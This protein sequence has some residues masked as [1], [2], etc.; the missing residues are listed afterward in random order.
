MSIVIGMHFVCKRGL[1]VVDH[2]DGTFTTKFWKVAR[3]HAETV[4]YIALHENRSTPSYRQGRVISWSPVDHQGQTRVA[5]IVRE[6]DG[7]MNW[8]GGGS[9]EKGYCWA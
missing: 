8:Q 9:G 3:K 4:E 7:A 1:H 5:F 6:E 2:A